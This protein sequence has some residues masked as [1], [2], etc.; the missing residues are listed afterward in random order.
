MNGKK[1]CNCDIPGKPHGGDCP[2]FT[3][4]QAPC[5]S[6]PIWD[7]HDDGN[8]FCFNCK[9]EWNRLDPAATAPTERISEAK[10]REI[11]QH[12][13]GL[14]GICSGP[15]CIAVLAAV[16]EVEYKKGVFDGSEKSNEDNKIFQAKLAA[17][18]KAGA[19]EQLE[20]CQKHQDEG[21]RRGL[22]TAAEIIEFKA[23]IHDT[24]HEIAARIRA[25]AGKG[26]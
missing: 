5:C 23:G 16:L 4:P 19:I 3:D 18:R 22:E 9:A 21:Y 24:H 8:A 10:A 12:L 25:K 20:K 15:E 13:L 6:N 1:K 26:K 14:G 11:Q 17:E 2:L 7:E